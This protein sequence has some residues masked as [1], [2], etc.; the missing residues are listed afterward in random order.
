MNTISIDTYVADI[1]TAVPKSAD[2]FRS[3]RIDYCCGGKTTLSEAT[4]SR[5]LKAEDV[6]SEIRTIEGE[7]ASQNSMDPASFG[8][9]T[10]VAYIQERYHEYLRKELK[11]LRP[12][13]TRVAK[14]HGE[15]NPHLLEIRETFVTLSEEL[16][17]HT[18]DED[19]NVFPLILEFLTNPTKELK[20][21]VKPHIAE[22][23][24]EHDNAGKLLFRLRDLTNDFTPPAGA[25]GTYRL[26]YARLEE[27]EKDTFEH[28]HLENNILFERVRAAI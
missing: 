28:V 26:V 27:L 16:I 19:K 6:L 12:Y 13:V 22:L 23:E 24:S 11:N 9:K 14:V 8:E 18:D 4:A 2:I 5:G 7:R 3:Y 10:L 1:V 20:E 15:K 17:D 25:C 21:K